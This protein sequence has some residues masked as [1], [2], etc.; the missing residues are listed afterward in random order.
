MKHAV[1][2]PTLNAERLWQRTV[3]LSRLTRP[4]APWTR[5]AF[6]ELFLRS[7]DWLRLQMEQ[8]GLAVHLDAGGNLVGRREGRIA[9]R[10]ALITGSHCDTVTGGGRYDGIVGV[11]AGIEVAH[12][13]HE[14]R[15]T[16]DHPLEVIDFLAEE[17]TDH[18]ISCVGSR[19]FA[20]SLDASMLAKAGPDGE[21]VAQALTR[22]GG[23]PGALRRAL[24]APGSTAAYVELH[25]EQGPVLETLGLPI[26]VVTHIVGI[27][28]VAIRV[29]GR[30]DHAGTTPMEL[31]HDALVG[32]ARLIGAAHRMASEAAGRPHYVVATVGRLELTPNV[33]NAVPGRVDMVLEVRS[34]SDAVLDS[35][36]ERLLADEAQALAALRLEAT[37]SP[38]SRSHPTACAPHLIAS[39]EESA[40]ALALPST[41]LPSGAGHDAA[42]VAATGPVGMIFIPCLDGRSH[43]AEESITPAQLLDGARVLYDVLLRLDATTS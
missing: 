36:P 31:R 21:T 30:A 38:L 37:H 25:I 2:P 5:R 32:A 10:P 33:P 7:R 23:D 24:R 27:R 6:S 22:I 26:G 19:A 39:I 9:G 4:D 35:F 41:R 20:G 8:A 34:D 11:L 13:L 15:R 16:L 12:A 28:R 42:H 43:C 18:G 40:R 1:S 3:E 17:P 14:Q 29:E